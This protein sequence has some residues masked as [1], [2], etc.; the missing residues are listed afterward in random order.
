MGHGFDVL[1]DFMEEFSGESYPLELTNFYSRCC[2]MKG[3]V[4]EIGSTTASYF[5]GQIISLMDNLYLR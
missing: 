1:A 2:Y 4:S 3:C 5:L